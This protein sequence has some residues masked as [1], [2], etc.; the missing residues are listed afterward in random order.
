MNESNIYSFRIRVYVLYENKTKIERETSVEIDLTDVA[1]LSRFLIK[2]YIF[3][4]N[5]NYGLFFIKFAN[6]VMH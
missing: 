6:A 3:H 2:D 1:S 4:K 5:E